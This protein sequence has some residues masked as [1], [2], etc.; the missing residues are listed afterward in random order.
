MAWPH[1]Q[2]DGQWKIELLKGYCKSR[3]PME[4]TMEI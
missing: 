2:T 4:I 1:G 3:R